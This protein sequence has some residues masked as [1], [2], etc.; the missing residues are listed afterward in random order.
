MRIVIDTNVLVSAMLTP[1]GN[2]WRVL[3]SVFSGL[4]LILLDE[5]IISE[6]QEV[7]K[8]AKFRL[9]PVDVIRLCEFLWDNGELIVS[10]GIDVELPDANDLP[11]AEVAVSGCADYLITGNTRHFPTV[12]K[13]EHNLAI[14]TP[15]Q[16]LQLAK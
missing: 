2:A 8:R 12:L 1:G 16:F 14:V 3:L 9:D 11:F 13:R 7:L 15:A 6:Y 4:N 5:R 10:S